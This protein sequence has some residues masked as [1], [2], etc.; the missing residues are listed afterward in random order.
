[1]RSNSARRRMRF[2]AV[3][4]RPSTAAEAA[5]LPFVG[6]SQA[7]PPSGPAS[8]EDNP[9]IFRRHTYPKA[10]RFLAAAG[11]GLVGALP[12]HRVLVSVFRRIPPAK[13]GASRVWRTV[14]TS[15][16]GKGVSTQDR[17]C[18]VVLQSPFPI[19][20]LQS[21]FC[22]NPSVCS[23]RFPQLWKTLWKTPKRAEPTS[24]LANSGVFQLG[25]RRAPSGFRPHCA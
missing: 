16:R 4:P 24:G 7:L 1:M 17:R 23:P 5:S 6:D 12:L 11:V 15:R 3:R 9:A 13:A 8:F 10:M 21:S 20:T 22:F 25:Q 18:D 2:A 14:N 19:C